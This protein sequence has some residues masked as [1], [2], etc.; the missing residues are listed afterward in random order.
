[1]DV[2][3]NQKKIFKK[4]LLFPI[5]FLFCFSL[6]AYS[7]EIPNL[8]D[9]KLGE[10]ILNEKEQMI[11]KNTLYDDYIGALNGQNAVAKIPKDFVLIN[12]KTL[13]NEYEKNEVAGDIKYLDKTLVV[14][15]DVKS[16]NKSIGDKYYIE[17]KGENNSFTNPRAFFKDGNKAFLA[18]LSKG[19]NIALICNGAGLN[20][21]S[22]I[23]SQCISSNEWIHS[24]IKIDINKYIKI[25]ESMNEINLTYAVLT[26]V[27]NRNI[28]KN[29][30]CYKEIL[31]KAS[32]VKCAEEC[33]KLFKNNKKF[34]KTFNEIVDELKKLN[35]DVKKIIKKST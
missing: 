19:E 31:N 33:E 21:G 12:S 8:K 18:S 24:Q 28:S 7:N 17:F 6:S 25:N 32:A 3:K 35:I 29:S 4:K 11:L 15:G 1:M 30:N 27:I 5:I 14:M 20:M 9:K 22:A 13:Q 2:V 10:Y 16:I 26:M 34:K 23:L